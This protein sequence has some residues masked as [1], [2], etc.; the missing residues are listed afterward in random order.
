MV[1]T[2]GD[3]QEVVFSERQVKRQQLAAGLLK[4][5]ASACP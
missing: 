1:R 4:T 5:L 2:I 3:G